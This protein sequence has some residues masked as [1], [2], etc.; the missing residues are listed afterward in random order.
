MSPVLSK[1]LRG[2]GWLAYAGVALALFVVAGF[3]SFSLFV[4]SGATQTPDLGGLAR[5]EAA[6]RLSDYGLTLRVADEAARFD[7][8]VPAGNVLEQA[9]PPRSLV[10]RGSTVTVTLSLGPQRLTVPELAGQSLQSA[11]VALAAAGLSLG[12]TLSVYRPGAEPG[13][14]V[15]QRPPAGDELPPGAPVDT[16]LSLGSSAG[17]FLMPDLVYRD[18]DRVRSF[19]ES[20]GFRL[21]SVKFEAYEGAGNGTILRQFPLPGHPLSRRDA[22]SLVVATADGTAP[23]VG[24]AAGT[25]PLS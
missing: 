8:E 18:Y 13:T 20:R 15:E 1:A 19:F 17:V 16:V 6:S 22:I 25:E 14:V 23:D 11:Q 5:V 2:L 9:P 10:K 7:A 3:L 24:G 4:R 12:R 21:G